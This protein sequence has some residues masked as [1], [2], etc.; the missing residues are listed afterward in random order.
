MPRFVILEHDHPFLH[1]DFMLEVDGLLK[2]WRLPAP[3]ADGPRTATAIGDH[4]LAY[5]DY[6]GPVSGAR[7]TVTRWDAGTYERLPADDAGWIV[8]LQGTRWRGTATLTPG[9]QG[10]WQVLFVARVD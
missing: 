8:E 10:E 1:W 4:R 7:G 6:Q 3:P 2:T 9:D 5:L